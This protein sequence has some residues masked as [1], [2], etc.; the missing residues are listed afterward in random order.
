MLLKCSVSR[1]KQR[2]L[3]SSSRSIG[4]SSSRGCSSSSSQIGAVPPRGGAVGEGAA[5]AMPGT[6]DPRGISLL[7]GHMTAKRYRNEKMK[8]TN[9]DKCFIGSFLIFNARQFHSHPRVFRR[10]PL[11]WPQSSTK[12]PLRPSACRATLGSHRPLKKIMG[13]WWGQ[14]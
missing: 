11:H 4:S 12:E 6:W 1:N 3:G 10:D 8:R 9:S 7:G 2:F 13:P 5:V 14:D